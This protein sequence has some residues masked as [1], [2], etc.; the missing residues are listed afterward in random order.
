MPV[1]VEE[2]LRYDSPAQLIWRVNAEDV[3][4][5]ATT[6]PAGSV[7]LPLLGSGNRDA[8][9]FPDPDRLDVTRRPRHYLS[10][11]TG[12]H[13]CIGAFLARLEAEVAL[14]A[15]LQGAPTLKLVDEP[16]HWRPNPIF[17]G[18]ERLPVTL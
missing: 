9:V 13:A 12:P 7:I 2:L 6:I 5:G 16:L 15:L 14:P 1:A 8:A 11:G 10:F 4:V 17:R 18:L 3:T